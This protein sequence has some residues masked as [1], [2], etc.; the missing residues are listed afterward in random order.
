MVTKVTNSTNFD[1]F[2]RTNK[3]QTFRLK[4]GISAKTIEGVHFTHI[5]YPFKNRFTK[6]Q[7]SKIYLEC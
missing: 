6:I 7:E 4:P 1:L 3:G 5:K 2:Y